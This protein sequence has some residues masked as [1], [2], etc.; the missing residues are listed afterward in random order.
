MKKISPLSYFSTVT[1]IAINYISAAG[2]VP[3]LRHHSDSD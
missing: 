3:T 2:I 1:G